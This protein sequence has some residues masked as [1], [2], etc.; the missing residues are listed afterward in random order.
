[1]RRAD[2]IVR[3]PH[4]AA[5]FTDDLPLVWFLTQLLVDPATRATVDELV[6]ETEAPLGAARLA[7]RWISVEDSL[8][9]ELAD[10]FR[11]LGWTAEEELVMVHHGELPG[12][13]TRG[14]EEVTADE[15]APLWAKSWEDDP[16]AGSAEA[17]A[18]LV[19][20]RHPRRQGVQV[21]YFAART[22]DGIA[23]WCELFSDGR[24]AQIENVLVLEQFRRRGLGKAVTAGAL[25]LSRHAHDLTFLVADAHDWPKDLYRKLGFE[26]VGSTW[27]FT[28]RARTA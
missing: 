6:A 16:D 26:P 19:E 14:V 9:S 28:R 12:I 27:A 4:G 20:A 25:S 22:E 1:M 23:G 24:V 5:L 17:V 15:L 7:H 11:A 2:R 18:Q 13:D 10:G 21:R 8:G 3:T